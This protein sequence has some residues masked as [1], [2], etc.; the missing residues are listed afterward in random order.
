[1]RSLRETGVELLSTLVDVK[2]SEQACRQAYRDILRM[3]QRYAG[4]HDEARELAQEGR[5]SHP[6]C[7]EK[8]AARER[9]GHGCPR[10]SEV[11]GTGPGVSGFSAAIASGSRQIGARRARRERNPLDSRTESLRPSESALRA[12][13]SR[14]GSR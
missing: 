12:S 1:M 10:R 7:V 14:I 6:Q 2:E 5:L 9:R 11:L 13:S 4:S 8:E 3:A